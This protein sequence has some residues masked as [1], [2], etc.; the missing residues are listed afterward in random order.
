MPIV[1]RNMADIFRKFSKKEYSSSS[2]SSSS[3]SESSVKP[4]PKER[5]SSTFIQQSYNPEN[6]YNPLSVSRS[7][8]AISDVIKDHTLDRKILQN[9][10]AIINDSTLHDQKDEMAR[11]NENL[12]GFLGK[13]RLIRENLSN[14]RKRRE[15]I[16]ARI[17]S[18]E[19]RAAQVE[20]NVSKTIGPRKQEYN[21]L[22]REIEALRAKNRDHEMKIR[23]KRLNKKALERRCTCDYELLEFWKTEHQIFTKDL[24][25]LKT[26]INFLRREIAKQSS[27]YD[28]ERKALYLKLRSLK[29]VV[30][31]I[32]LPDIESHLKEGLS[33]ARAEVWKLPQI[34]QHNSDMFSIRERQKTAYI[35]GKRTEGELRDLDT[36]RTGISET[37]IELKNRSKMKRS[38]VVSMRDQIEVRK[39][40]YEE[41]NFPLKDRIHVL[42]LEIK[43]IKDDIS[44]LVSK[45]VNPRDL[46]AE[47]VT[48]RNMLS[49]HSSS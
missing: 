15:D 30:P 31:N 32:A 5:M 19:F 35:N 7:S 45:N 43:R 21:S 34:S 16:M 22:L 36:R 13:D 12:R 23:A 41:S 39:S 38:E 49:G 24:D 47:I 17:A 18:N 27:A 1:E 3:S 2:S 28:D 26:E 40:N 6:R 25:P 11:L 29:T 44:M 42:E 48:M 33:R 4:R 46:Q 10:T 8:I 14:E 9:S 37:C 20:E